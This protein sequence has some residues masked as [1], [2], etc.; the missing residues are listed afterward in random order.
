MRQLDPQL[1][2]GDSLS[3]GWALCRLYPDDGVRLPSAIPYRRGCKV[4]VGESSTG[5][6][7]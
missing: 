1:E 5:G 3:S 2:E 6:Y 4:L 7:V